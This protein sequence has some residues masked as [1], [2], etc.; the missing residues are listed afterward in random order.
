MPTGYRSCVTVTPVLAAVL[1]VALLSAPAFG[2]PVA[3]A[4][5]PTDPPAVAPVAPPPLPVGTSLDRL[6]PGGTPADPPMS[7]PGGAAVDRVPATGAVVLET[8]PMPLLPPPYGGPVMERR[9]MTGDWY[10]IRESLRDRGMTFDVYTTDFGQG[11]ASGGQQ[12]AFRYGGR[13]DYLM[14]MDGEKAGLWQGFF[15]DLHGES[16]YGRSVNSFTGALMPINIAEVVPAPKPPITALTG[17]KFTQALS[18]NFV[19]FGGKLNLLDSF[20]QPYTGGARGVDGFM[21]AGLLLPPVLARTIPYST[22]GGG[23]AVLKDMQPIFTVMALDPNNTPT[24]SGFNTFFNRGVSIVVSANLPTNF[25]DLP[26][27]QGVIGTYSNSR[28]TALDDLPYFLV[29]QLRGQLQALPTKTGSWSVAYMFDQAIFVDPCDPKRSWGAFGN[30]GISDGNPNPIRWAANIGIGG[31][32]PIRSR[33]LDSFGLGYYYIGV[34]DT[35]K[36]LAAG[37]LPVRDEH[38]LELFYNI[39]FTQWCH[40]TPDL[41]VISPFRD[42]VSTSVNFCVRMKLDF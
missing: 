8:P 1:G 4:T 28:Y 13:A 27:H 15:I 33:E 25:F 14:H 11:V 22:F 36:G 35:M 37:V 42:R 16:L 24:V 19:L 41:Q 30:I 18:E 38:G 26:G 23:F 3:G 12:N 40:V 9:Y 39:G 2:Q 34:S 31:A 7:L 5:A 6:P 17:V 21:D 20:N 29:Q 32:S 10:G